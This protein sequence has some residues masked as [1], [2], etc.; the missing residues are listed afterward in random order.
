MS[1]IQ[2]L[3]RSRPK[4]EEFQASM[5]KYG[6]LVSNKQRVGDVVPWKSTCLAHAV[7]WV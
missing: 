3:E 7:F 5:A 1:V 2:E 4:N 6:D